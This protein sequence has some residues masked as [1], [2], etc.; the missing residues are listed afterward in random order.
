MCTIRQSVGR[1]AVGFLGSGGKGRRLMC[2]WRR[3]E[4][5]M[6]NQASAILLSEC[7]VEPAGSINERRYVL[8][9]D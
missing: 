3:E 2:F 6:R 1:V 5:D 9:D 7:A 4:R 8:T